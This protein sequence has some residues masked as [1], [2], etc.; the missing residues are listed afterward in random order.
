M[1]GSKKAQTVGYRYQVGMHMALCL[2]PIDKVTRI[3]VDQRVAWEGDSSIPHGIIDPDLLPNPDTIGQQR[4]VWDQLKDLIKGE[5]EPQKV[6]NWDGI[7]YPKNHLWIKKENLFGGDKREGGVSGQVVIEMGEYNQQPHPYLLKVVP[8]AH[9]MPAYRGVVTAVL[10]SPYIGMN[11]YLKPWSFRAQRVRT[12][13]DGGAQWYLS[14][15]QIGY[16]MNPIHIIREVLVNTSPDWG[17]SI[18]INDV[19]DAKMRA[20]ADRCFSE[21][22][23]LSFLWS[24]DMTGQEFIKEVLKHIDASLVRD[25][26]TSKMYVKL[27]RDDYNYNNLRILGEDTV[28]KVEKLKTT[29]SSEMAN[30]VIVKFW[31]R[32]LGGESAVTV[33]N[34]ALI[35]VIGGINSTTVQ[36]TGC[37]TNSL[38][39]KLAARDLKTLSI[40]II[41]VTIVCNKRAMN[42]ENSDVLRLNLPKDNIPDVA[43]RVSNV[44]YDKDGRFV[45]LE[46]VQDVFS[47]A[48][49]MNADEPSGWVDPVTEPKPAEQRTIFE[50]TYFDLVSVLGMEA[51]KLLPEDYTTF[52]V[53]A[54]KPSGLYFNFS[55]VKSPSGEVQGVGDFMP[56]MLIANGI[57]PTDTKFT[58]NT[59]SD[60]GDINVGEVAVIGDER[61]V[62]RKVFGNE[63][64]IDRGVDD[65]IP[66][67]HSAGDAV[68]V[69]GD[70]MF[71]GDEVYAEGQLEEFKLLTTTPQGT[72]AEADAPSDNI[73]FTGRQGRPFPPGNVMLEG[74]NWPT[75]I[76]DQI[77]HIVVEFATRNRLQQTSG[78]LSWFS[79]DVTNEPNV[80]YAVEIKND[81]GAVVASNMNMTSPYQL[82]TSSMATGV[83]TVKVWS[84]RNSIDS[85]FAYEH[86]FN[87]TKATPIR[88]YYRFDHD[89]KRER[90]NLAPYDESGDFKVEFDTNMTQAANVGFAT[91]T[92]VNIVTDGSGLLIIKT[93]AGGN[94]ETGIDMTPYV[95]RF[96]N[97]VI[98]R[99]SG[100]LQVF[101]DDPATPKFTKVGVGGNMNIKSWGV[102]SNDEMAG[103][104][105]NIKYYDATMTLIHEYAVDDNSATIADSVGSV[106][107]AFDRNMILGNWFTQ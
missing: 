82:D 65:T 88:Y 40:P 32:N 28:Y 93:T 74:E 100:E 60:V 80:Q 77:G 70:D 67:S 72:L 56:Y 5:E 75:N 47:E 2:G 76:D 38:A 35:D 73:T 71:I 21:G 79:P 52:A 42:V 57:S 26:E 46:L 17:M 107:G 44:S 18:N 23:G 64:T 4:P 11:P 45:K 3:W 63:I 59:V 55:V 95:N 39:R 13:Y 14:R 29:E 53:S 24:K 50:P 87:Y 91:S 61:V 41:S 58:Y 66:A 16:D 89:G 1:G 84:H 27:I 54:A 6:F 102:S 83:H 51:V 94:N 106:D 78:Y 98:Q 97:V 103:V 48:P 25:R 20:A 96:A 85:L 62:I 12:G 81:Q 68:K 92:L 30:Q 10:R 37:C 69:I 104:I 99:I 90:F 105:A 19:D 7:V 34:L 9:L 15:A 31:D 43:F 8:E 86:T 33:Q 22:L 36:Y 101:V 49:V